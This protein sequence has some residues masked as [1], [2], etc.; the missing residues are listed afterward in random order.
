M[1]FNFNENLTVDNLDKVP[2]DFRGLYTETTDGKFKLNSEDATVGSAVK[3][4]VGLNEALNASRAEARDLKGRV[5]DLTP[6]KEFGDDPSKILEGFNTKLED[7]KKQ[8]KGKQDETVEAQ[9]KAAREALVKAHEG[10][11]TKRDARNKALQDQLYGLMVTADA[12]TALSEAG[13][14]NSKLVLPFIQ[15]QVRVV[16]EDGSFSV[17]V[18]NDKGEDRFSGTTG[19]HMS[20]KELV[21]EMKGDEQY[22]PLFKSD[23]P[24]GG[25]APATRRTGARP[26]GEKLTS[27]QKIAVGIDKG[28]AGRGK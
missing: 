7:A 24:A 4:I 8:A 22:Q 1:K 28:Q 23:A 15:Q 19:S 20:I 17:R 27:L 2:A 26:A 13:A 5:V 11:L 10:E 18:V 21:A 16:E 12:T 6:L 25:G 9:I 3:A 14:V